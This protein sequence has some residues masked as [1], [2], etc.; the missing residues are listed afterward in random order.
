MYILTGKPSFC[1]MR[2]YFLAASLDSSSLPHG[3]GGGGGGRRKG[4]GGG[5]MN[6]GREIGRWWLTSWL[7]YTPSSLN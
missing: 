3:G 1:M 6:K 2:A 5:G 4:E 7:Q